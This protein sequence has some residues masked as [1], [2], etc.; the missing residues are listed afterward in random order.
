MSIFCRLIESTATGNRGAIVN[1]HKRS[2]KLPNIQMLGYFYTLLPLMFSSI[3][4]NRKCIE[5]FMSASQGGRRF[6]SDA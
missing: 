4:R 5:I 2:T 6:Y 1:L 3:E